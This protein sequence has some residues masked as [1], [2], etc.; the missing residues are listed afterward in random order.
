MRLV[1]FSIAILVL[2]TG[3]IAHAQVKDARARSLFEEGRRL[4]DDG[5][6]E[7]ACATLAAS[8]RIEAALTTRLSLAGCHERAGRTAS[9]Y[10]EYRA[11]AEL[12]ARAGDNEWMREAYALERSA[13][14][15][16]KLVRLVLHAPKDIRGLIIRRGGHP[17]TELGVP[18]AVDPGTHVITASAPGHEPWTTTIEIKRQ[19]VTTIAIPPL[20]VAAPPPG[21]TTPPV[22]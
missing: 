22:S 14:L 3:A 18:V 9:A 4:M 5:K 7:R 19:P 10:A 1:G 16:K 20:R 2:A 8:V 21:A 12:A 11:S 17:V 15:E 6:L 13:V